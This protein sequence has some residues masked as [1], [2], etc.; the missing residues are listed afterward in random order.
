M[1]R[2]YVFLAMGNADMSW[3]ELKEA[4]QAVALSGLRLDKIN[5]ELSNVNVRMPYF[6]SHVLN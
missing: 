1:H 3:Q 5:E 2:I 4:Y 6:R